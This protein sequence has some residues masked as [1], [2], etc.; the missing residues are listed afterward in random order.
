MLGEEFNLNTS[1][2][3]MQT[4]GT[5]ASRTGR[6]LAP[7]AVS[8]ANALQINALHAAPVPK[9]PIISFSPEKVQ[10]LLSQREIKL[11]T[12]QDNAVFKLGD[13]QTHDFLGEISNV[14]AGILDAPTASGKT[15]ICAKKVL[16]QVSK[17]HKV[18]FMS[19]SSI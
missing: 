6:T 11:R 13:W 15:V 8:G 9:K 3:G 1:G 7:P 4:T 16:N 17:R 14:Q 2:P 19:Q 5:N 10:E 18:L 12:Y